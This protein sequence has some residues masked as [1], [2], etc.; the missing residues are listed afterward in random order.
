MKMGD[1]KIV[2]I[3]APKPPIDTKRMSSFPLPSNNRA[4]PGKIDK[5][6]PS[7]GTPRKV[8]GINSKRAWD[9]DIENNKM[10]KNSGDK[11]F[12]KN[13][14]EANIKAPAVFT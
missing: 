9:M 2:T 5:T 4:C 12:N 3:I 13:G 14:D 1:S 8:E 11:I 10:H 7:S 6:V